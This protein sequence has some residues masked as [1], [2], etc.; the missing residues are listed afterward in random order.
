MT[1]SD[2]DDISG[3]LSEAFD[4]VSDPKD[5]RAPI[6][7]FVAQSVLDDSGITTKDIRMAITHYT[8]TEATV[9]SLRAG[10]KHQRCV[11]PGFIFTAKG[12]RA[13]PAGP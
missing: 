1:D 10:E 3:L 2:A 5:W 4:L 12:Y 6:W 7:A 8:A 11:G 13:G 9:I